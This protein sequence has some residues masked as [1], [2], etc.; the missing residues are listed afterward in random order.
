MKKEILIITF[1]FLL[2]GCLDKI[3][4]SKDSIEVINKSNKDIQVTAGCSKYRMNSYPDT[5]LSTSNPSLLIVRSNDYNYLDHSKEWS[6]V[7]S[8]LPSDTLSVY[9]F[10]SDTI[11]AYEWSEIAAGYK[12]LKRYDLS[13]QDLDSMNWTITYP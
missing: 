3:M 13:V 9:I 11:N 2:T 10:D 4:E 5:I 8:E 12:I 7:I 1:L 6:K